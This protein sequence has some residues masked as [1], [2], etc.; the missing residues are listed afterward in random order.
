M[1]ARSQSPLGCARRGPASGHNERTSMTIA[2]AR[3]TTP[4]PALL[5]D[6]V[7]AGSDPGIARPGASAR[8]YP[9]QAVALLGPN[10]SGK[11][12]LLKVVLGLLE[13]LG[14]RLE[15]LGARPSQL[16]RSKRQ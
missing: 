13:P 5:L 14:G 11:S 12:T 9:G 16:D 2:P 10:G 6:N 15:A 1:P 4:P 3:P 8:L 7:V